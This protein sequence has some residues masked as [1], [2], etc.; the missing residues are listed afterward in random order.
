V[1]PS[2]EDQLAGF[3][4]G[5]APDGAPEDIKRIARLC[6]MTALSCAVAGAAEP[7]V[8]EVREYLATQ[9][10]HGEAG[11]FLYGDRL[12]AAQAAMI[13]AVL[14]RALDYC[15]AMAPGL[16]IGSSLIPAALAT[17]ELVG[18][19]T[20][21][22]L[23]DAVLVGAEVGARLNLDGSQYDGFDP[24]G[25]AGVFAAT[26]ACARLLRLSADQTRHALGLAFNRSGGSFQSNVDGSLA[27]RLI[28][29]WVAESAVTCARLA[30]AGLTGPEHFLTGVYGYLHLFGRDRSTPE[31]VLGDLGEQWR[32]DR[33]VFKRFPSCGGTQAVTKLALDLVAER[34]VTAGDLE[35]VRVE[36][37]PYTHRLVGH[38]FR[39]GTDP[40]VDAQFSARWCVASALLRG[41]S[42]LADFRPEAVQD[43]QILRLAARV[44]AVAV[45]ELGTAGQPIARLEVRLRDGGRYDSAIDIPPGF[46]GNGLTD[47]EHAQRI[48]D[49]LDYAPFPLSPE[50]AQALRDAVD[51]LD[52]LAD[53]R[54]LVHL[55]LTPVAHPA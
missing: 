39:V 51:H 48:A 25:V 28:Q 16:H 2:A 6:V 55:L 12:P 7:G 52:E 50:R 3:V 35:L 49:C 5:P 1:T 31:D 4:L 22:E 14:C 46:P 27:V 18:G 24:T 23:L 29:G 43:P 9:G 41:R 15:D 38:P 40:R 21:K 26:A 13:N 53:A 34:P 8:A 19:C 44:D 54:E 45:D 30:K 36:V 20:G 32:L 37:P 11:T 10:G 33:M 17:A 42:C 47:D